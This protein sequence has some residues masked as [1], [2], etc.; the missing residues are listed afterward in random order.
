MKTRNVLM[1]L[2]GV[3]LL[4]SGCAGSRMGQ[5]SSP[6]MAPGPGMMM[7]A[8]APPAE[9]EDGLARQEAQP[10]FDIER[11][12]VYTGQ[13]DLVVK[14][15]Q[16]AQDAV[17]ALAD[18]LEGYIVSS[19]SYRYSEGLLRIELVLRVPADQFNAAMAQLR[20]LATEVTRDSVS[21]QDVTQEYVDLSARLSALEAKA[22][23]LEQLMEQA[24]DTEAV[25]QVYI[26][27]SATQME[28]EQTKGRMQY[29]ERSAAMSTIT[30]TL[31]PDKLAQPL[32]IAGWRPQGIAKDALETLIQTVQF[33]LGALIWLLIYFVPVLG[34]VGLVVYG[35][36]RLLILI[37]R[38]RS[39]K[40][41]PP[42][43]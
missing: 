35:G 27:L 37:F 17:G 26:E 5:V 24:E 7:D 41:V 19:N 39:R 3:V 33:L 8:A 25:L 14:D 9:P 29:L 4:L 1:L 34:L 30:V 32:E 12:I 23:R 36:V 10:Q 20:G 6:T 31:T 42:E 11:M 2:L 13:L 38:R 28:I 21:S 18:R 15:S 16:V 40:P 22:E 43:A